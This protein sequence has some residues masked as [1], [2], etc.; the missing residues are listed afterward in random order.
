LGFIMSAQLVEKV[1]CYIDGFN[2]Y[3]GLREK[4]WKKYYWLNLRHLVENLFKA[5]PTV[6]LKSFFS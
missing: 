6:S 4:G 3:Y 1:V 2:L 5:K